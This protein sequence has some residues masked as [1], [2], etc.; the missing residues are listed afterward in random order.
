MILGIFLKYPFYLN[1]NPEWYKNTVFVLLN[2]RDLYG[3]KR[4]GDFFNEK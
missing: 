3:L 4:I 2:S 1:Y